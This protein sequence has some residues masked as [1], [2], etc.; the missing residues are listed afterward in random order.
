MLFAEITVR[1]AGNTIFTLHLS[2]V[3]RDSSVGVATRHGLD[4]ARIE[5]LLGRDFPH[6]SR[7]SST[8]VKQ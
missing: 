6:M 2:T 4:G 1:I 3:A 5:S 7:P 8:A